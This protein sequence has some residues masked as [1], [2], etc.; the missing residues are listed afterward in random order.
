[1]YLFIC[2][3]FL[4]KYTSSEGPYSLIIAVFYISIM[5]LLVYGA[6]RI[7]SPGLSK[8]AMNRIYW[9]VAAI[10]VVLLFLLMRRFDPYEIDVGRYWAIKDWITRLLNGRFPYDSIERPSG[11]PFLFIM[12]M[13]F[14]WLGDTGMFQIFSFAA[15][16]VAIHLRHIENPMNKFRLLFLLIAAPTFLFEIC[17][18][19]ELFSNMTMIVL[20]VE[21]LRIFGGKCRTGGSVILGLIGGFLLS[22]RGLVLLIYIIFSGYFFRK[23]IIRTNLFLI[24]MIAGFALTIIPFLLW[25]ARHFIESGPLAVQ[26]SYIPTW[27]V[28]F[29]FLLTVLLAFFVRS[30][31]AAYT[32]SAIILFSVVFIPFAISVIRF[33]FA[34]SIIHVAFDIAYFSFAVPFLLMAFRMPEESNKR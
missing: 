3:L 17:V 28:F 27:L 18:R 10:L 1:M 8:D 9:A 34:E 5:P 25:N 26:S 29:S 16:A 12:A 11:F 19:S 6:F 7:K 14:Y 20:Y 30:L 22:T 15:F 32:A 2:I 24:S 13:P 4:L 31:N 23:K 33:G 21:I